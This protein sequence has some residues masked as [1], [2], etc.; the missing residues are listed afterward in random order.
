[1]IL[2]VCSCAYAWEGGLLGGRKCHSNADNDLSGFLDILNMKLC[3]HSY[4]HTDES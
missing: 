3:A 2:A 1:M 4:S